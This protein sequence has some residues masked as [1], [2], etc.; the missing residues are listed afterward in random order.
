M[1]TGIFGADGVQFI[2]VIHQVAPA[3]LDLEGGQSPGQASLPLFRGPLDIDHQ[4][5]ELVPQTRLLKGPVDQRRPPANPQ[6][7]ST[8]TDGVHESMSSHGSSE[9]NKARV[10]Q[11]FEA[12]NTG[13]VDAIVA[14][15]RDVQGREGFESYPP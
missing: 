5:P 15:V 1:L 11:F 12:M 7:E 10:Q 14:F 6:P 4:D 13:D 8:M 9:H 2:K 3:H